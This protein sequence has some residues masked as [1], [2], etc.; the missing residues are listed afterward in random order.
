MPL[1][2]VGVR[3]VIQAL[4]DVR[5]VTRT[6]EVWR[7]A[8]L[9]YE[10]RDPSGSRR[11]PGRWHNHGT[12]AALY[13]SLD[14]QT[15]KAEYRFRKVDPFPAT[16]V[17]LRVTVDHLLDLT[18]RAIAS[19]LPFSLA[20]CLADTRVSFLRGGSWVMRRLRS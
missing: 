19:Y 1:N 10:P 16:A 8:R 7:L 3:L 11:T 9:G 17:Q 15:A 4:R 2:R 12:T 18:D 20:R 5:F 14:F 13:T 6:F